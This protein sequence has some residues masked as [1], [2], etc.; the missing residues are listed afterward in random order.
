LPTPFRFD[1]SQSGNT[2]DAHRLLHLA[3]AHTTCTDDSC[4]I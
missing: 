4:A 1:R 2:F 3:A